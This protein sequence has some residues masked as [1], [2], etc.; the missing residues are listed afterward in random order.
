MG[1]ST[2]GISMMQCH[3]GILIKYKDFYNKYHSIYYAYIGLFCLC[4]ICFAYF[5]HKTS[6]FGPQ[7]LDS[8]KLRTK[9]AY[10]YIKE[11]LR[12]GRRILIFE[13]SVI[14]YN[15]FIKA[16]PGDFMEELMGKEIARYIYGGLPYKGYRHHRHT[17]IVYDLLS[18]IEIGRIYNHTRRLLFVPNGENVRL[19]TTVWQL[20]ERNMISQVHARFRFVSPFIN[21]R[22]FIPGLSHIGKYFTLFS[23]HHGLSRHYTSALAM[24]PTLYLA[25]TNLINAYDRGDT[26]FIALASDPNQYFK[27]GIE[28]YVKKMFL[29]SKWLHEV[30]I[31]K[32]IILDANSNLLN[33]KIFGP[34]VHYIYIY[35]G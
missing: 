12:K 17:N 34:F 28:I 11:E 16:H 15:R 3:N 25:H 26:T 2:I 20:V 31:A 23:F 5:L 14:D 29:L 6:W 32:N 35:L 13:D 33:F 19:N 10:N 30:P 18:S 8:Q 27:N 4:E 21:T 7:K 9:D 22:G 1:Y 24:N